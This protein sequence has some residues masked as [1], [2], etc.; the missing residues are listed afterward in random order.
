MNQ[1]ELLVREIN[2]YLSLFKVTDIFYRMGME[3]Q[4]ELDNEALKDNNVGNHLFKGLD[5]T[6]ATIFEIMNLDVDGEEKFIAD[7]HDIVRNYNNYSDE[8]I[9][10]NLI[11]KFQNKQ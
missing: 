8:L 7:M 1:Q 6:L 10:N 5:N 9:I 2:T 3:I 4:P 11:N